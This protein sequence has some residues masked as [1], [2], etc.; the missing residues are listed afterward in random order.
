MARTKASA[1]TIKLPAS[2][3]DMCRARAGHLHS[4]TCR[5][6]KRQI[7]SLQVWRT[8]THNCHPRAWPRDPLC[9]QILQRNCV[10]LL[11]RAMLPG[12]GSPRD[13]V[14]GTSPLL[15]GLGLSY[16]GIL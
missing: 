14:P 4:A 1:C 10:T 15:S 2:N 11:Q 5:L 16:T 12:R 6:I 3:G 9:S 7:H 13:G 8:N